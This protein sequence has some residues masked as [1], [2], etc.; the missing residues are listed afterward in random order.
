MKAVKE[1]ISRICEGLTEEQLVELNEY[2][3]KKTEEIKLRRIEKAFF[4]LMDAWVTYR[5]L[6]PMGEAYV[7]TDI[8]CEECG[9]AITAEIEVYTLMD[10]V[11]HDYQAGD[12]AP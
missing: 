11:A 9:H 12:W 4:D 7:E 8:E 5:N 3:S 6:A 10:H 2:L 1:E